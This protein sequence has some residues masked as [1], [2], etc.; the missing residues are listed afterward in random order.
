MSLREQ[1]MERGYALLPGLLDGEACAELRRAYDDDGLFRKRV[2]MEKHGFGRGEYKYFRYPLPERVAA[3][4]ERFYRELVPVANEWNARLKKNE[5]FPEAEQQFLDFCADRGQTRPTALMLK[6]G[7][8]DFNC[9]HE[10]TYGEVSFPFQMTVFLSAPDAYDG[11]EFVLVE[12][13][14]RQQS[15]PIVFRPG[16]GDALVIPNRYR[17]VE[18]KNGYYR[19]TF[20]HGVSEVRSGERFTLGVIFHDAQ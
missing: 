12:Q 19:T 11:G 5:R 16:L 8:G 2:V 13:R 4:R 10:D 9:L 1:L 15:R 18:G 6:Y 3:M 17:P 20:R 7:A 14:P